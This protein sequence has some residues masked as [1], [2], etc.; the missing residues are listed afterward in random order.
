[1]NRTRRSNLVGGLLLVL[2][3]LLV[4]VIQLLPGL[5]IHFSWPWIIIGF[6]V[7]LLLIGSATGVAALAI[8]AS[9]V[10]GIGGILAYQYASGD[11]DS[12]AYIWSL[13]PGFVG[14]GIVLFDLLGGDTRAAAG[15]GGWLIL[16]S[17]T[18]F[19]IFGS[20]FGALGFMGQYWPVLLILLGILLLIR[21]LLRPRRRGGSA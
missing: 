13:I 18:L 2:L 3:G 14:I 4:L 11:W 9:I 16:I 17:L 8:P 15:A 7:L 21:P 5:R 12:W 19:C 6:G 20:V 10:A 1:M